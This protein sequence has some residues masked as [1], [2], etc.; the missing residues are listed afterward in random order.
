MIALSAKVL[1]IYL[2]PIRYGNEQM[3]GKSPAFCALHVA[4]ACADP[5]C[6]IVGYC[7]RKTISLGIIEVDAG[8]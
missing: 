3:R 6:A 2:T 1:A 7:F 8:T 5:A 4:M